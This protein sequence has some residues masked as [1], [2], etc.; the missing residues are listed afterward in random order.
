ML[1]LCL[2][3]LASEPSLFDPDL[4][5]VVRCYDQ[6]QIVMSQYFTLGFNAGM[7]GEQADA[8]IT[9]CLPDKPGYPTEARHPTLFGTSLE[10]GF[11]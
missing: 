7:A 2:S 9:V 8:A 3:W 1:L 11:C 10:A 4:R 5:A 6:A